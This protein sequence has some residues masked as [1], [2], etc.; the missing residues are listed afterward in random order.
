MICFIFLVFIQ[1]DSLI[2]HFH[3]LLICSGL[4]PSVAAPIVSSKKTQFSGDK[5]FLWIAHLELKR[6]ILNS[7]LKS[8]LPQTICL[9]SVLV[10][11][12]LGFEV[13]DPAE[14]KYKQDKLLGCC[15][16]SRRIGTWSQKMENEKFDCILSILICGVE[17]KRNKSVCLDLTRVIFI[18]TTAP[19]YCLHPCCCCSL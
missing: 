9:R 2:Q 12:K 1:Y 14:P 7:I 15:P 10:L 17:A 11:T 13:C 3:I 6:R 8:A 19:G 4:L 5:I 16:E 18:Q